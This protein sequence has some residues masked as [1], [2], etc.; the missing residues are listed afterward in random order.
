MGCYKGDS[1]TGSKKTNSLLIQQ[2]IQDF[3]NSNKTPNFYLGNTL[4]Q[5]TTAPLGTRA[6]P[7]GRKFQYYWQTSGRE[8]KKWEK[9]Q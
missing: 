8:G 6:I 4:H 3:S 1:C 7:Q 2:I 5:E 9:V